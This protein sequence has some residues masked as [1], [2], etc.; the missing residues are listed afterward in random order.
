MSYNTDINEPFG[1]YCYKYNKDGELKARA[2][3]DDLRSNDYSFI[4]TELN[5]EDNKL[6]CFELID[7]TK[8][9][10]KN[11]FTFPKWTS[12]QTYKYNDYDFTLEYKSDYFDPTGYQKHGEKTI[13]GMFAYFDPDIT[14]KDD[15]DSRLEANKSGTYK[16]VAVYKPNG[17]RHVENRSLFLSNLDSDRIIEIYSAP[18]NLILKNESDLWSE[19][20]EGSGLFSLYYYNYPQITS[21]SVKNTDYVGGAIDFTAKYTITGPNFTF[22]DQTAQEKKVELYTVSDSVL[23]FNRFFNKTKYIYESYAS[24]LYYHQSIEKYY[25]FREFYTATPLFEAKKQTSTLKHW[26]KY[27]ERINY[28]FKWQDVSEWKSTLSPIMRPWVESI[29]T[30]TGLTPRI[31]NQR[32]FEFSNLPRA[33]GVK[34]NY[35]NRFYQNG[36]AYV[37]YL[38]EGIYPTA[39]VGSAY[40][41]NSFVST[42]EEGFS[43]VQIKLNNVFDDENL[44]V[45]NGFN[46][47]CDTALI[48]KVDVNTQ[49]IIEHANVFTKDNDLGYDINKGVFPIIKSFWQSK[50]ENKVVNNAIFAIETQ[51]LIEGPDLYFSYGPNDMPPGLEENYIGYRSRGLLISIGAGGTN[52][53]YFVGAGSGFFDYF[54]PQNSKRFPINANRAYDDDPWELTEEVGYYWQ[55]EEAFN[56]LELSGEYTF[57]TQLAAKMSFAVRLGDN[58]SVLLMLAYDID[59]WKPND[60]DKPTKYEFVIAPEE[61]FSFKAAFFTAEFGSTGDLV[62]FPHPFK[63]FQLQKAL[64]PLVKNSKLS[65][66]DLKKAGRKFFE[67][68]KKKYEG[69]TLPNSF[70]DKKWGERV[71]YEFEESEANNITRGVVRLIRWRT[72]TWKE[73][74]DGKYIKHQD[75]IAECAVAYD[76]G[77]T[78]TPDGDY[79][80]LFY[81]GKDTVLL[82]FYRDEN[83][84]VCVEN[85]A[86]PEMLV[87]SKFVVDENTGKI[88]TSKD[89]LLKLSKLGIFDVITLHQKSKDEDPDDSFEVLAMPVFA[90]DGKTYFAISKDCKNWEISGVVGDGFLSHSAAGDKTKG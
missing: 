56:R 46:L 58:T 38:C 74:K 83:N 72:F 11:H 48:A 37:N 80:D 78:T 41:V 52:T 7:P 9:I 68:E 82:R 35:Y 53:N 90:D 16:S 81:T 86:I 25:V 64:R 14:F 77:Q 51:H 47:P 29:V 88:S 31:Y 6:R 62:S 19:E 40:F 42:M 65:A 8:I 33:S 71:Q 44:R 79:V 17:R 1:S 55:F 10:E 60:D 57:A 69:I 67:Y 87:W 66:S 39:T 4:F 20:R 15:N 76:N 34:A 63:D 45:S 43:G 5:I 2:T 26:V 70:A 18:V 49:T 59:K 24:L 32:P 28:K 75:A 21:I 50:G 27:D 12:F 73:K 54:P 89:Y 23:Y 3:F 22:F 13:A 85:L 61:E 36:T 84:E 30:F